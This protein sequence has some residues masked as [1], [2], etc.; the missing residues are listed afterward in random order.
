MGLSL[1]A[2]TLGAAGINVLGG[3][4]QAGAS[5]DAARKAQNKQIAW[6]RERAQNAHQW[7]VQDLIKAGLN[8]ILSAG[9]QGASTGGI[10]A[11]VPDMSGITTGLSNA[12]A[13]TAIL[14]DNRKKAAETENT[15]T[16]SA[17]QTEQILQ[18]RQET[19]NAMRKE[20][21]IDAEKQKIYSENLLKVGQAEMIRLDLQKQ[22]A[23]IQTDIAR[24]KQELENL[25]AQGQSAKAKAKQ[26]EIDT[27]T[28]WLDKIT[29]YM[30]KLVGAAAGAAIAVK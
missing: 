14:A 23:T 8:P 17:L 24:A 20:G 2:A 28:K 25:K 18:T 22:Y 4:G 27:K 1:A 13:A 16:N 5:A 6:E 15:D 21:L 3:L 26:D 11:P 12:F 19:I 29:G 30:T 10:S 9:G 7:E